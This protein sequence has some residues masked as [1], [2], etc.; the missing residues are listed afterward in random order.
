MRHVN[1]ELVVVESPAAAAESAAAL[2]VTAARAGGAIVLAGGSTP[3]EAYLVAARS[4][5][6]W[7][8]AEVWLGDER[9]VPRDDPRSNA[10]L[11]RE[12]LL[13]RLAA[14]P[15]THLVRTELPAAEAAA[16]YD[17]ELRGARLAFA[18]LG[19]G[20]DAHTASL[21]PGAP[22]LAERELLA[23][24]A[25]P[26]L[27][28]WVDRVTLTLPA[29]AS[30]AEVVFLATGSAKA[31][32]ARRAFADQPSDAAPASL[33]RSAHGR[34]IAVLDLDAAALIRGQ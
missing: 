24:A 14:P 26:G 29:L 3:R 27:E 9:V 21:F 11:V 19:L 28:P 22:A 23:V 5:P 12:A 7:S 16:A 4:E 17:A 33:V 18:L 30:A 31:E 15:A 2:L 32:A 1:V 8:R 20:P 25:K 10:R 6:D 13:E 34:T